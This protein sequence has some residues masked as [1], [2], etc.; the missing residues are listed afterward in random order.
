M[1]RRIFPLASLLLLSAGCALSREDADLGAAVLANI[2]AQKAPLVE[3]GDR[4]PSDSAAL[5]V[6]AYRRYLLDKV[7]QPAG[8]ES[9]QAFE[10]TD[11]NAKSG[12]PGAAPVPQD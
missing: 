10:G 12:T 11:A 3:P 9:A 1:R 5:G 4:Q 2:E 7:K 8:T 6:A